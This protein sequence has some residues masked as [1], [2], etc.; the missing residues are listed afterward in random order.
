MDK[1]KL[2]VTQ[3]SRGKIITPSGFKNYDWALNTYVGCQ[4]GCNYCYVR[5]FVKDAKSEWGDFVRTRDHVVDRLPK[6]LPQT[7][8]ERLVLGTMTDPYQPQERKSRLTRLALEAIRDAPSGPSKV[9]IFTRSPIVLDDA[10]LIAGLPR[11]RV[12][13]SITPFP[14][15][16]MTKLERIPVQTAARFRT[17]AALKKAGIRVHVNVAPAIPHLSDS[18][19]EEYC[20]EIARSGADEFFVD[21]MQAY[22]DSYESLRTAMVGDPLWP[23]VDATMS[24]P[25]A[26]AR[27]KKGY[28][29]SWRK[30]WRKAG[31]PVGTLAI[32]CD[33]VHHVWE[34]LLTGKKLDPR[35][36]GDDAPPRKPR[37][38]RVAVT[39]Q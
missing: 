24:D 6:E 35:A 11:A 4:F 15:D 38:R 28:R 23:K 16:L 36:Y 9:G 14:K 22:S 30:A 19:T 18:M 7:A 1:T 37:S 31:A 21:P 12:H 27:W 2:I 17:V 25:E 8:G 20:E 34:E 5:F 33:H 26:F 13:L 29:Q 10:E 39:A 3:A 32:W